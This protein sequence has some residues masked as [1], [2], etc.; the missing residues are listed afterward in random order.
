MKGDEG[1]VLEG[2][3]SLAAVWLGCASAGINNGVK[4]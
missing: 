3:R 1:D 4:P 2:Q